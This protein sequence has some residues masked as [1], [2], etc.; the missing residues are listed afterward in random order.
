MNISKVSQLT[1]LSA[2]SIRFYES[3]QLISA[4]IRSDNGYRVYSDVHIRQLTLISRAKAV[5]FTLEECQHLVLLSGN[6]CRT[7]A[8][9]K[10]RTIKK[11]DEVE[12]KIAEL[13]IIR[14][15]LREWIGLCPGD[16]APN[17]PIMDKLESKK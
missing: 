8:E 16:E 4:P 7:S 3:K 6:E 10:A 13:K 14:N 11:L 17:C 9:I 5:G 12:T 15:Q 1:H 2:K